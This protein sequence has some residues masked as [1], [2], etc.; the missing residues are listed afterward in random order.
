MRLSHQ[1][2]HGAA[3][4][5]SSDVMQYKGIFM[6]WLHLMTASRGYYKTIGLTKCTEL[7]E[8]WKPIN[9]TKT[10]QPPIQCPFHHFQHARMHA[11]T[12][13]CTHAQTHTYTH[14]HM[15]RHTHIYIYTHTYVHTHTEQKK[16]KERPPDDTDTCPSQKRTTRPESWAPMICP[17]KKTTWSG[18][19]TASTRS[20]ISSRGRRVMALKMWTGSCLPWEPLVQRMMNCLPCSSTPFTWPAGQQFHTHQWNH[21]TG[22]HT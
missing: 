10:L 9:Y 16:R 11:H 6:K 3:G 8:Q 7:R 13:T 1:N 20:P 4:S 12:H 14:T 15:H 22:P 18:S 21:G 2:R 19:A 5:L 17:G